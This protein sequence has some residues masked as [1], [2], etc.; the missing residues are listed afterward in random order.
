MKGV[1]WY[2]KNNIEISN[3]RLSKDI[4]IVQLSKEQ[5]HFGC[6]II[7]DLVRML[8]VWPTKWTLDVTVMIFH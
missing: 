8:G 7:A 1:D 3:L 4:K 6:K 5:K 2:L